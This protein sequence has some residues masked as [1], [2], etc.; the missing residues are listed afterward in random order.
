MYVPCEAIEEVNYYFSGVFNKDP[1]FL[2][3]ILLFIGYTDARTY[4]DP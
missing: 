2:S 1:G 3:Q 4:P